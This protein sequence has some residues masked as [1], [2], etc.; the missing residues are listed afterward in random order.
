MD[1]CLSEESKPSLENL[2]LDFEHP[3]PNINHKACV[4]MALYWPDASIER[5]IVKLD[6]KNIEMRRKSVKA[7]GFFGDAALLPLVK[8]FLTSKDLSVRISCL[9][10]FVKIAAI[11]KY[12]PIPKCLE[13]VI[14]IALKDENPQTILALVSLLRQL[15]KQGLPILILLTRDTNILRAKAAITAL[16]EIDDPSAANC[17]KSLLNDSAID[18]LLKESILFSMENYSSRLNLFDRNKK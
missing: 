11:E 16:G 10:V 17:L 3:N 14:E 13:E 2:F 9:K 4:D 1:T 15:Y 6:T 12:D 5:L 18:S 7:L 8:I